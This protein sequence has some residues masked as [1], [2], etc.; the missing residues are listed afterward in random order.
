[1]TDLIERD[2][3]PRAI[4]ELL[5]AYRDGLGNDAAFQRA[6]KVD[7]AT[8]ARRFDAYVRERFA[9]PLATVEARVPGQARG[10][11]RPNVDLP[12]TA[13]TTVPGEYVRR[14][15]EAHAHLEAGRTREAIAAFQRAKA[16]FPEY[17]Q[18]DGPYWQLA[19]LYKAAGDA[20]KAADELSQLTARN[21][22][23]YAAHLELATLLEGLGDKAGAAAALDGAIYISPYDPAVHAR[24]ATLA[25]AT[26]DTR[27]VVRERR[28][29]LALAPVDVADARFQLALALNAAGDAAGAR[30][31]LL[32]VLEQA[33]TFAPAQD[34]LLKLRGGTP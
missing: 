13:R 26:G 6:L 3:G 7:M 15:G 11:A 33:P 29:I 9:G 1:V 5:R 2:F 17:A 31:E 16:L 30:R 25:A 28:A 10:G 4:P 24:L 14:L 21:G 12:D 22:G 8:L 20:R 34:L 32:Q 19:M 27:R 18:G 23:H